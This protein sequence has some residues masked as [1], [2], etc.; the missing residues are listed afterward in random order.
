M[1]HRALTL[2]E[3][4]AIPVRA[5]RKLI[6]ALDVDTA[7]EAKAIVRELDDAV[8][9]YK[10]GPHL[11]LDPEL[12]GLVRYLKEQSKDIFLDFKAFD[13]PATVEG[14]VRASAALGVKF[15]T[16]VGQRPIIKAAVKARGSSPLQI[17]VVTLLTYMNQEDFENEY[18][19]KLPLTEFILK[20]AKF[21]ADNGCDGVI[22]SARE[23]NLI[24]D[25]IDRDDFVI[26]TPGIRSSNALPDDQKRTATPHSAISSGADYLVI[27][28]PIVH[29][30]KPRREAALEILRE[31]E[32]ALNEHPHSRRRVF[33]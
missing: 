9:F 25:H 1:A 8:S 3:E 7:N 29:S 33:A 22:S 31:M 5:R 16:V 2:S 23:A 18:G 28:R 10:I 26:V 32:A 12:H 14:A 17:L 21:A 20:R 13:I 15:I 6:V 19:S 27:G 30:G 24:Q 11:L 4:C